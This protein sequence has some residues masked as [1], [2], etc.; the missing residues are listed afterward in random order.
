ML[1]SFF[2]ETAILPHCFFTVLPSIYK[3]KY[4]PNKNIVQMTGFLFIEHVM[5]AKIDMLLLTTFTS[6]TAHAMCTTGNN[7]PTIKKQKIFVS[8]N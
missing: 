3:F 7:H 6:Y 5:F 1:V 8:V 4:G 2:S